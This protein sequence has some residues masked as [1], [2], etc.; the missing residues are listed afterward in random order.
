MRAGALCSLIA[1]LAGCGSGGNPDGTIDAAGADATI[2]PDLTIVQDM[3]MATGPMLLSDTGLYSD[4]ASRTLAPGVVTFTARYPLWSDGADKQ[5]Y[6]LLP[7]GT[8]IDTT[9]M[10]WWRFPV[11]TKAW[12]EFH[13]DGRLV[14]TRLL[15]KVFDGGADGWWKVAYAWSADG[16]GAVAQPTGV[17]SALGTMHDIPDQKNCTWCHDYVGDE[18]IG[19]SAIQLSSPTGNGDL[20]KFVMAGMLSAPPVSEP[21]PPGMGV[22]QDT[23][24]YLHGNCGHCHNERS[25]LASV[26]MLKMRLHVDDATPE[27]TSLYL[28]KGAKMRHHMPPCADYAVVSANSGCSQLYQRMNSRDFWAMPPKAPLSLLYCTKIVDPTGLATV[29]SWIDSLPP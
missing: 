14:E 27:A 19:V 6:F 1:V 11:G 4:F 22:V 2:A 10:D 16:S 24:G 26:T 29:G 3:T 7:P 9:E 28:S 13:V 12:K 15:Q 18:L 5:R 25:W 23:L 20:T 17:A 21:Q 8:K